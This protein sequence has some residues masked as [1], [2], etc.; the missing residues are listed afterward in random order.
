MTINGNYDFSENSFNSLI[1]VT[2]FERNQIILIL[3]IL[4][5]LFNKKKMKNDD[6]AEH[7]IYSFILSTKLKRNQIF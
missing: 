2:K 6:F 3:N 1:L 7:S 5:I 4:K